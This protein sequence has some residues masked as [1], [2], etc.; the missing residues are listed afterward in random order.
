MSIRGLTSLGPK[1]HV[2]SP[3]ISSRSFHVVR[4][5]LSSLFDPSHQYYP[6]LAHRFPVNYQL[7]PKQLQGIV[8]AECKLFL[9]DDVSKLMSATLQLAREQQAKEKQVYP[10]NSKS[11][12]GKVI[13][14]LFY[15]DQK[16]IGDVDISDVDLNRIH[17][18]A[19]NYEGIK[20]AASLAQG[21]RP[22]MEDECL[23]TK[24]WPKIEGKQKQILLT[25]IFDGHKGSACSQ[26]LAKMAPTVIESYLTYVAGNEELSDESIFN[27][28]SMA[29]VHL[30]Q[31]F[32]GG[33]D[34]GSTANIVLQINHD[35]WIVNVGDSRTLQ[36]T[37]DGQV[38]RLSVDAKPHESPFIDEIKKRGG[39]VTEVP[40]DV[41]R[42]LG[43]L[44]VG[45]TM[46][47]HWTNGVVSSRPMISK[48]SD[49]QGLIVQ[50]SD[51]ISEI[52]TD[53]E[54]AEFLV[55]QAKQ[56]FSLEEIAKKAIVSAWVK[57]SSDN[58]SIILRQLS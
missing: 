22:Y 25:A 34:V 6:G 47:D 41:P 29:M 49:M 8:E 52:A 37:A 20:A 14:Y 7:P 48:I 44:N 24:I 21:S 11:L 45:T 4:R 32:K 10:P 28:L 58:M 57:G 12:I 54:F 39:F 5:L 27:A 1:F 9:R 53:K 13:D 16:K 3:N 35:L 17:L 38:K 18:R 23:V 19:F 33:R 50:F 46:G 55:A 31:F 15:G 56:G 40:N 2:S 43:Q 42:A 36:I 51:G 30:T 26:Y